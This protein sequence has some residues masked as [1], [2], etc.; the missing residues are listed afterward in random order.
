[1][2]EPKNALVKQYQK[3]FELDDVELEF[4]DAA[5]ERIAEKAYERKTGARG[6][7][8]IMED[9]MMDI[10]YRIPSDETIEKC[11]VTLE[12]VE[13]TKKPVEIHREVKM[14]PKSRIVK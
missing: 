13:G 9:T 2:K 14:E 5:V 8:S 11:I 6:L 12:S 7:R 1:M 4:D 10:M 3:L